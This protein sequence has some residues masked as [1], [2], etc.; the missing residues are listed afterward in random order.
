M[1]RGFPN[2]PEGRERKRQATAAMNRRPDIRAKRSE[3]NR[4]RIARGID[5]LRRPE[6]QRRAAQ[7]R[8]G[9]TKSPE[10][11]AKMSLARVRI[12]RRNSFYSMFKLATAKQRGAKRF[13]RSSYESRISFLLAEDPRVE[14]WAFEA[15]KIGYVDGDFVRNTVPDFLVKLTDGR[16]VIVESK[17]S[18]SISKEIKK[19]REARNFAERNGMTYAVMTERQLASPDPLAQVVAS[20]PWFPVV[21][22]RRRRLAPAGN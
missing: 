9:G 3:S 11:K 15:L 6:V 12:L 1:P 20:E 19:M 2:T 14:W 7:A 18:W 13:C 22:R 17:A 8:I 21:A 5:P 16:R 10:T 4:R